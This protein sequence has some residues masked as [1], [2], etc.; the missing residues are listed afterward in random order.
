V[1]RGSS[2]GLTLT[3]VRAALSEM[4][5]RNA[6]CVL[7]RGNQPLARLLLQ[8]LDLN[9]LL[10]FGRPLISTDRLTGD[11][12]GRQRWLTVSNL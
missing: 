11:Q 5:F 6:I 7:E 1:F 9:A 10:R 2:E 3:P 12:N 4:T 8:D